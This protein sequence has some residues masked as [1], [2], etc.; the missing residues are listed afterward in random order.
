MC[1]QLLGKAIR[2]LPREDVIICTKIGK[3]APGELQLHWQMQ[4]NKTWQ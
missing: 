4:A 2:S 1:L 3:Y